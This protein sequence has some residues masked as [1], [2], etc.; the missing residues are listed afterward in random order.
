MKEFLKGLLNKKIEQKNSDNSPEVSSQVKA[1]KK[2]TTSLFSKI[3]ST[4]ASK[5]TSKLGKSAVAGE[6]IIGVDITEKEIRLAQLTSNKDNEW[7]LENF[8]VSPFQLPEGKRVLENEDLVV[9]ALKIA[10]EKSKINVKNVALAIPVTNAIIR[11][12]ESPLMNDEEMENA[13]ET[14][15]LWENLIQLTDNLEDYSVF[16]QIISRNKETN[17]MDI[18]FVASKLEDIKSYTTII[19]KAGLVPVIIDVKCFSI[20]AALDQINKLGKQESDLT[21]VLEFGLDENYLMILLNNNPIIT[22]VFIRALDREIL[23]NVNSSQE[24][25][26]NFSHRYISQV[27]QAIADFETKYEKRIRNIKVIS[28][29]ENTENFLGMFRKSLSNIGVTLLE[30]F[31]QIKIPEH[32]KDKIKKDNQSSYSAVLGLAFRKLDVFGYYK[33]VTAVKNIN[34]LPNRSSVINQKKMK[35]ISGFAFKGFAGLIVSIYLVLFGLAFWNIFSYGQK[36]KNYSSVVS[37]FNKVSKVKAK[38]SKELSLIKK[39]IRLSKSIK[40]NKKVSYRILA[41]IASSVPAR[42]YFDSITYDGGANIF[43]KGSALSDQDILKLIANLNQKSLIIQASL[44]NMSLP[45][46]ARV[47]KAKLKGFTIFCKV[48]RGIK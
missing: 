8:F 23:S 25:I 11:V 10:L 33:F 15:S 35:A 1:P 6:E 41:Q 46:S 5:F 34:L 22:D 16:H 18:L 42:V 27:K 12:V 38:V 9:D 44:G 43:I 26:E 3:K 19:E 17:K 4:L 37:E 13:L 39:S 45:R 32:L 24:D 14:N 40:S 7:I 28:N 21:T 47:G 30:P 29:L 48:K 20:K 2:E 31:N 36:I